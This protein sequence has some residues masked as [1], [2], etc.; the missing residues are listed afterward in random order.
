M[1]VSC[2][3]VPEGVPR[4]KE[5]SFKIIG[6]FVNNLNIVKLFPV[7]LFIILYKVI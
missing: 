1:I 5:E 6:C 7:V 3:G 4:F 2:V